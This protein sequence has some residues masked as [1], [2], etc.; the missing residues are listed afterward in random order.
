MTSYSQLSIS[1]SYLEELP[2]FFTSQPKLWVLSSSSGPSHHI[3]ISKSTANANYF[4][5]TSQ[6]Y[7]ENTDRCLPWISEGR[8]V[9]EL[10]LD[11]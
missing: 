9:S 7:A 3:S 2:L 11:C 8:E 10:N 4:N 5:G 1:T 6:T